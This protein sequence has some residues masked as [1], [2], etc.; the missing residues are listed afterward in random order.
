MLD[1][2]PM[3]PSL[4]HSPDVRGSLRLAL[5]CLYRAFVYARETRFNRWQ[6]AVEIEELWKFGLDNTELRW[7]IATGVVWH[8]REVEPS[9]TQSRRFVKLGLGAIQPRSCFVLSDE[10]F[11]K[12]TS[13]HRKQ[14]RLFVPILVDPSQV[15]G[16]LGRQS[17]QIKTENPE[18]QAPVWNS[19]RREL[20]WNG[21]VIKC[22]R[23]PAV[24][25]QLIVEA[26]QEENWPTRIDDPLPP[27]PG[28]ES[29][30]R[31]NDTIKCLNRHQVN[32]LL[33]FRGDGLGNGVIWEPRESFF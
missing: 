6:F 8:A 18:L 24:N 25:Q 20:L 33:H 5:E 7:L 21:H 19:T 11:L 30:R 28:K 1:A 23:S 10:G 2:A 32:S 26:F 27:L 9:A 4:N 14:R 31:L 16:L 17:P 13:N 29:S 3:M 15:S 22:F 12:I